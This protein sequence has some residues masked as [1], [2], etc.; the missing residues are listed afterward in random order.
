MEIMKLVSGPG[1]PEKGGC[2][3]TVLSRFVHGEKF[4]TARVKCVDP[5]VNQLCIVINDFLPTDADRAELIGPILFDPLDTA[6]TE[7]DTRRRMLVICDW[8]LRRFA[9]RYLKAKAGIVLDLPKID[10]IEALE[11]ARLPIPVPVE[12]EPYLRPAW[13]ALSATR[14]AFGRSERVYCQCDGCERGPDERV[15]LESY[16]RV[17]CNGALRAAANTCSDAVP[18][19]HLDLNSEIECDHRRLVVEDLLPMLAEVIAVGPHAQVE[20]PAAERRVRQLCPAN[21]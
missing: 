15:P 7:D 11:H 8:T 6:G 13:R 3:M 1:T 5:L 17:V 12:L 21:C 4:W 14:S 16:A 20:L 9:G 2:W 10:S 19:H 18:V